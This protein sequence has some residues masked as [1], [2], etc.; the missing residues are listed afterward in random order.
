MET[1]TPSIKKIAMNYGLIL[2]LG[3]IGLSVVVW[4][5]GMHLEQPWWQ[6]LLNFAIMI[7]CIIYGL[8]AYKH[9]NGGFLSLGEALKT[10]LAIALIA[11]IVGVIF[12]LIFTTVI[13]PNFA[14]DMLDM[15][16]EKMVEANPNM[17]EEQMEMAM[18]ITEK[19]MSPGIMA[20]MGIIVTLFFGFIIS[21]I[22]GLIMKNNKP[23][24]LA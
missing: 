6:G 20:A 13:E 12:N 23:E 5:L 2:A 19:M 14:A 16:R 9:A 17:N 22:G 1:P 11:G 4:A 18:G 8:K 3:T 7:G 24:H 15:Q 21:L 10:G